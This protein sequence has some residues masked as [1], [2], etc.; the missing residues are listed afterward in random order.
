MRTLITSLTVIFTLHSVNAQSFTLKDLEGQFLKNNALLIAN[1]YN[2]DKADVEIIQEKLWQ[3][4]TLSISE[5]N[6][7][8]TYAVEEQPY[9]IG[10]YGAKIGMFYATCDVC[11]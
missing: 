11:F 3:N 6:L 9:L 8:K 2:I 4:P 5:V 10:K 7:W 1:K